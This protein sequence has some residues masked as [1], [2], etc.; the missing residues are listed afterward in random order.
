[1]NGKHRKPRRLAVYAAAGTLVMAGAVVLSSAGS[2][3]AATVPLAGPFYSSS[4]DQVDTWVSQHPTDGRMPVI[5]DRIASQPQ[6]Y[7]VGGWSSRANVTAV[8]NAAAAQSA[9]AVLVFYNRPNRDCGGASSGGA[10]TYAAYDTWVKDMAAGLGTRQVAVILEPDAMTEACRTSAS[11]AALNR[12]AGFIHA[13]NAK[14][15]IYYDIGHSGWKVNVSEL[16]TAGVETNGD[17]VASNTSN[18]NKTA[19][20]II[21]VKSVLGQL[22]NK[23][24]RAVIDVSR[25]G[26][27]VPP[28]G[29]WCNPAG[30]KL[31]RNPTVNTGDPLVEA[32]LWTKDPGES[33]GPCGT[34]SA[35]AGTFDPQLAYDLA[36]DAPASPADPTPTPTPTVTATPT[37]TPT[38]TG[39]STAAVKK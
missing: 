12:A 8:T 13:A 6:A 37:P 14:A 21:Y 16:K 2:G 27:A 10:A 30:T 1:M 5:R 31:G 39:C 20:E 32:L 23:D 19:D 38:V 4:T 26:G 36:W 29:T 11:F 22:S 7:W 33:D 28:G 34:S 24:L 3:S 17:G 18:F 35:Q 15:K 25:N 9:T